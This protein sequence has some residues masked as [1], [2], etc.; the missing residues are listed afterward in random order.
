MT[1]SSPPVTFNYGVWVARYPEFVNIDQSLAQAYFDEANVYCENSICNPALCI[2][3]TLLNMLT[4]HIAWLNAPRDAQGNPSSSGTQPA[5][6]IVGRI[7]SA[8]EG[9]VS[10]QAENDYPPGTPQ[11]YQQ[12]KYGAAFWAATAPYRTARY[13]ANPTIVVDAIYPYGPGFRGGLS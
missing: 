4:A 8:T 3:P 10:V 12:S 1:L 7:S 2:L 11:W 6:A 13:L 5:S 9:S